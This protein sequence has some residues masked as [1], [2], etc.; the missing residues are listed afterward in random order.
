MVILKESEKRYLQ[1][2]VDLKDFREVNEKTQLDKL[3]KSIREKAKQSD[4]IIV[5][6]YL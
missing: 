3:K 2:L 6:I 5:D 4:E 1:S